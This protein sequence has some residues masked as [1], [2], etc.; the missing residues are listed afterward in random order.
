MRCRRLARTLAPERNVG[1]TAWGRKQVGPD[2]HVT[3]REAGAVISRQWRGVAKRSDADAYVSHLQAET[4]PQLA[5]IP[6]FLNASILRRELAEGTEFRIITTWE[7]IKA[8]RR[9]AGENPE[10]AVVPEKVQ[11]MMVTYDQTVEHYEV[12]G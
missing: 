2:R 12:V 8:I 9:F 4:F 3:E 7:S 1:L 6:G 11:R 10:H 5:L